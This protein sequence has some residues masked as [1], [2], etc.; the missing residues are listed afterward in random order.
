MGV[1]RL[2]FKF[3]GTTLPYS[4]VRLT[5]FRCFVLRPTILLD[6]TESTVHR[7]I[8]NTATLD[9][10][11]ARGLGTGTGATLQTRAGIAYD[12]PAIASR[13]LRPLIYR[14][15]CLMPKT[16][17]ATAT[18]AMYAFSSITNTIGI[19][20]PFTILIISS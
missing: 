2:R 9:G 11:D 6:T 14:I 18:V 1:P 7:T 5:D 10:G 16:I 4:L 19:G 20:D 8:G 15:N 12:Q 13:V 3:S 17:E